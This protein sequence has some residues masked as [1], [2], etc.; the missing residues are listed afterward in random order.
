MIIFSSPCNP[1]GSVYEKEELEAIAKLLQNHPRALVISDEIY[2]YIN[3]DG[4]H[5]SIASFEGMKERTFVVNGVSKG[6]A[7]TGWRLGFMAGPSALISACNKLQGQITSGTCSI[8]QMAAT[9][10]FNG[11]KDT[12]S[13][14]IPTYLERK[15]LMRELLGNIQGLKVNDPKGAFYLFVD[16]SAT[17]GK[18]TADGKIISST[19]E[20]AHYLLEKHHVAIV[21]GE[22]FGL[23]GCFRISTAAAN[24]ELSEG[25]QRIKTGIEELV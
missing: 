15:N 10:A 7:M 3:Y 18:K 11:G 12:I 21:A 25:A 13:Y 16:A 20:L 9:A 4:E 5:H 23:E 19:L 24:Q 8:T 17:L 22:A 14:M 1:T 2:E 6:F